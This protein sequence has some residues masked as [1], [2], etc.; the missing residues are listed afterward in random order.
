MSLHTFSISLSQSLFSLK[1]RIPFYIFLSFLSSLFSL[2]LQFKSA[3]T[4][5]IRAD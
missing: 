3:D 2:S 4:E 1:Y 5:R